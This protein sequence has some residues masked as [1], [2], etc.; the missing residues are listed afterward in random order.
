MMIMIRFIT[1]LLSFAIVQGQEQQRLEVSLDCNDPDVFQ[2][3]DGQKCI[4]LK[5]KCDFSPD[6]LDGSDEP[7]DCPPVTC[8]SD[9]FTC[10]HS[11]RCIPLE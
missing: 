6:C 9:Q 10:L 8:Q 7:P 4:P 1:L 2:C 5:W 3:A 11:R